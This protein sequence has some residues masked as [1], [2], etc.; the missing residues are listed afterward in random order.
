MRVL[1]LHKKYKLLLAILLIIGLA[2]APALGSAYAITFLF[3]LL[4]SFVLAQS[5]DWVGGEMGYINLGHYVFYGV[6]AYAFTLAIV[7]GLPVFIC[8]VITIVAVA[9][10]AALL[11]L[12]IFRL[13]GDYFA[14]ATLALLPLAK[15]LALNFNFTG[16]ADG[17]SLP[18]NY[19]LKP[20]YYIAIALACVTF[21]LTI[22]LSHTRLGYAIRAIR[23]DEQAAETSGIRI[24]PAKIATLM[25]SAT[26][27]SLAGAVQAWQMSYIDPGTVFGLG[28]GLTPI[29]MALLGGSGLLWGP[30]VG[31]LIL[32]SAQ[33]ILVAHINMLQTTIYGAIILLIGR[34]MPGGLLRAGWIQRIPWVGFFTKEHHERAA[35]TVKLTMTTTRDTRE[36]LPLRPYEISRNE[37]LLKCTELTMAF[38]GNISVNNV[39]LEIARGEIVG[40]VGPNGAGKSTLFNCISKV[41]EPR[42]GEIV[43]SGKSFLGLRR[44][45]V[46]RSGVGR[47]YQ[48]PRPFSDMTVH[49]NICLPLMFRGADSLSPRQSLEESVSLAEFAGLGERLNK[50]A[51]DLTLQEKKS[52]ELAR[53]LACQPHLL[54]IDEVASGLTPAEIGIFVSQIRHLRDKYGISVIWI[55]HIFSAL[56][57]VIDRMIVLENGSVI[58]DGPLKDVVNDKRVV[59]AYFGT[60]D[61]GVA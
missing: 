21:V 3:T 5:W 23:N 2:I 40:L 16:G 7:H 58:A 36:E 49:E 10:I 43:F 33:H 1:L 38:G 29:A 53:A 17:L 42:S 25:L 12:P 24:F 20:A 27:A 61:T 8:F 13:R 28:V 39:D 41:Y 59:E 48:I 15:L 51:D 14:F 37:V 18:P 56:S 30:L 9:I 4:V 6:G 35:D 55:E 34:F 19:V 45:A 54:L 50:R 52:L 31:V 26:F 44:D 47:T 22:W 46:S 57:Q 11:G 32:G 60:T